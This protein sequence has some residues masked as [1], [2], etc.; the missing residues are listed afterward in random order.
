M[1]ANA[2]DDHLPTL[3]A[4]QSSATQWA[5]ESRILS[6]KAWSAGGFALYLLLVGGVLFLH[7][8]QSALFKQFA[9]ASEPVMASLLLLLGFAAMATVLNTLPTLQPEPVIRPS[10]S[11]QAERTTL[12]ELPWRSLRR[13]LLFYAGMILVVQLVVCLFFLPLWPYAVGLMTLALIQQSRLWRLTQE[14]CPSA[15]RQQ[16]LRAPFLPQLLD[17]AYEP[18]APTLPRHLVNHN[19]LLSQRQA[20]QQKRRR[21]AIRQQRPRA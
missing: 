19:S 8:T 15:K 21:F 10:D 2:S 16:I 11:E 20:E 13:S 4:V 6:Y 5:L 3:E 7:L 18:P 14:L 9:S 12:P 1:T 17:P